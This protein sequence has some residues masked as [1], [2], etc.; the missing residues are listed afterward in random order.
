EHINV[1]QAQ[2]EKLYAGLQDLCKERRKR[3]DE[4]LQLYE[5]HREIDDLLQWIADKENPNMAF[6]C[7]QALLFL[8]LGDVHVIPFGCDKRGGEEDGYLRLCGACQAIRR[9]PDTFFPPF[10]NEVMCDDDKAC[11]Y[12][13]DFRA[14]WEMHA[15]A[16]EFCCIEECRHRRL[17]N[18]AK[19]QS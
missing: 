19:I 4:T 13:Y 17:S 11:L 1:R 3:L 2:I 16:Y 12:F 9:L 8:I 6:T 7:P 14:S 5:L 10:I 18:M 15:E